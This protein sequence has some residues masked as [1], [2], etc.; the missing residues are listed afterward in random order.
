[1]GRS[2]E[3]GR[4]WLAADNI[5]CSSGYCTQMGGSSARKWKGLDVLQE[6]NLGEG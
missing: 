2:L 1:M 6:V 3:N 5:E 4:R